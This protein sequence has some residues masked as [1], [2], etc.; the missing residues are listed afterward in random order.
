MNYADY[1]Y[2]RIS[3]TV[4][5]ADTFVFV[6][7]L[8]IFLDEFPTCWERDR[9]HLGKSQVLFYVLLKVSKQKGE[10]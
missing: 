3:K 6:A 4:V 1:V 7:V 2:G 5:S 8:F 10:I 9:K